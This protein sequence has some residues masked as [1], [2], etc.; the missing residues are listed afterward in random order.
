MRGRNTIT[1]LETFINTVFSK[2]L[3]KVR[4][5]Y[6]ICAMLYKQISNIQKN[7]PINAIYTLHFAINRIQ[8][9]I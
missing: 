1:R 6:I 4:I 9:A 8:Y 3:K 2:V 5:S 7:S